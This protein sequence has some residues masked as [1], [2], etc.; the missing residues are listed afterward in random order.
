MVTPLNSAD[1]GSTNTTNEQVRKLLFAVII[2][3]QV[4]DE[5]RPRSSNGGRTKRIVALATRTSCSNRKID[6]EVKREDEWYI[7]YPGLLYF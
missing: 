1:I 7:F 5:G 4:G 6:M 2:Y 3:D